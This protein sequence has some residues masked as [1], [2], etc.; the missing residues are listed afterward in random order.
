MID[1]KEIFNFVLKKLNDMKKMAESVDFADF[2]DN[3]QNEERKKQIE[4]ANANLD[5]VI[6]EIR[7]ELKTLQRVGE[8]DTYTIAFY[9]ETNAGK[10]TLIEALRLYFNESSKKMEQEHF[11]KI[12][13]EFS[14]KNL[15]ISQNL[16]R[17]KEQIVQI[18]KEISQKESVIQEKQGF[19][20]NFLAFFNPNSPKRT[21]KRLKE[22]LKITQNDEIKNTKYREKLFNSKLIK[23]LF[24]TND[25]AIIGYGVQDFTKET[26]IFHFENYGEN[27]DILD[28]PGIEGDENKVINEISDAT[29]KAHCVFYVAKKSKIEEGALE[30][31]KS[32]LNAQTE[33]YVVFNKPTPSPE[34]LQES[35][36]KDK[37]G[38]LKDLDDLLC[39]SLNEHYGGI[40]NISAFAAFLAL[41]FLKEVALKNS[42]NLSVKL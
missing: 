24:E 16:A 29:K 1:T 9:G 13:A 39:K 18:Q 3:K 33:V 22:S 8:F 26:K 12:W 19:F 5:K 27:F 20:V 17:I 21:L 35:L 30:K 40:K 25:G 2:D 37:K 34:N 11:D 28:M 14:A 7:A 23:E 6:N 32:H 38:G 42:R 41:S 31:I 36:I 4:N 15:L 10:S